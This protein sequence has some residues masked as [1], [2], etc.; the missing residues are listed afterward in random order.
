MVTAAVRQD[1]AESVLERDVQ[2]NAREAARAELVK[3]V[4]SVLA[5]L[6]VFEMAAQSFND[7]FAGYKALLVALQVTVICVLR[8]HVR[9]FFLKWKLHLL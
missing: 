7:C 6:C 8:H 5:E 9:F 3:T 4:K 2:Y 1:F